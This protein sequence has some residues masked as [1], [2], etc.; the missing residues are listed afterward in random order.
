MLSRPISPDEPL[1]EWIR[2]K[3]S[4]SCSASVGALSR[5]SRVST[6]PSSC[7]AVS[8]RYIWRYWAISSDGIPVEKSKSS[9]TDR[10]PVRPENLT[11]EAR[12]DLL[13]QIGGTLHQRIEHVVNALGRSDHQ[14]AAPR[15]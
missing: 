1:M 10:P 9:L 6:R 14:V 2:R 12:S 8:S 4:F 13:I 15:Q 7:S 5:I 11:Y 3:A